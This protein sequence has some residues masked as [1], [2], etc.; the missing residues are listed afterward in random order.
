MP[1]SREM[2]LSQVAEP[3]G[4]IALRHELHCMDMVVRVG[5]RWGETRRNADDRRT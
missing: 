4:E 3:G 1:N 2:F 5:M